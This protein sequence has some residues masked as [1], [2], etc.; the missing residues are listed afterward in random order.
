[1]P[2]QR[3]YCI[4]C[5]KCGAT[6]CIEAPDDG[7]GALRLGM[8]LGSLYAD[9][10]DM[11]MCCDAFDFPKWERAAVLEME[12]DYDGPLCSRSG[13]PGKKAP[14][15]FPPDRMSMVIGEMDR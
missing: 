15:W 12:D 5:P 11:T 4:Q 10:W 9:N 8:F 2:P 14:H 7:S 6:Y 3:F 13:S 1:M